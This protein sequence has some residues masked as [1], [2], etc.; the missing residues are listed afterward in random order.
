MC[1][2]N[3]FWTGMAV[4][5]AAGTCL[6]IRLKAKERKISRMINRTARNVENAFDSMSR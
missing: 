3:N 1:C 2:C 6:G 5:L 4:G